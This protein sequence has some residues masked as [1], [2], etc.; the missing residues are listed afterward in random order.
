VGVF[1]AGPAT[2]P[3]TTRLPKV[4]IL[5]A[6]PAELFTVEV[7]AKVFCDRDAVIVSVA[8][9]LRGLN[10]VRL[11]AGDG[12]VDLDSRA[13]VQLLVGI[14]R[15]EG[16]AP[17]P[18]GKS[19]VLKNGAVVAGMPAVDVY[20]VEYEKGKRAVSFGGACVVLGV[21]PAGVVIEPRD[22]GGGVP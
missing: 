10:G 8:P 3:A 2:H 16:Y 14:F 17:A 11:R 15:G 12:K 6:A 18:A 13:P 9:E 7:G 20:A 22:A 19:P 21:I 1:A 5:P 4:G